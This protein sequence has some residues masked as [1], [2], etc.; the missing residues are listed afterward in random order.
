MFVVFI[1]IDLLVYKIQAYLE[2][3]LVPNIVGTWRSL[4]ALCSVR[5]E[6]FRN[7][8]SPQVVDG[9]SCVCMCVCVR[10]YVLVCVTCLFLGRPSLCVCVPVTREVHSWVQ[11]TQLMR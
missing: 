1:Y 2:L 7:I 8:S 5:G 9:G 6:C 11:Q 4:N 10:A 3:F